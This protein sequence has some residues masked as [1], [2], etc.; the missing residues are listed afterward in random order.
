MCIDTMFI[1]YIDILVFTEKKVSGKI[2]RSVL[3]VVNFQ[4]ET[5]KNR[6]LTLHFILFKLLVSYIQSTS[7]YWV[8]LICQTLVQGAG[9]RTV[10]K[11]DKNPGLM[12]LMWKWERHDK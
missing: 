10:N 1:I 9:D 5:E 8:P 3:P 11:T 2:A 7:I 12:V 4:D 6:K